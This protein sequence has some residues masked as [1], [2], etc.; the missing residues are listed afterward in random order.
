[1]CNGGGGYNLT[2]GNW[3][4]CTTPRRRHKDGFH[5]STEICRLTASQLGVPFYPDAFIAENRSRIEPDFKLVIN[6]AETN[7]FLYD[8]I[9]STGV[10]IRTCRQLLVDKGHVVFLAVGIMNRKID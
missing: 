6:P 4:I 1:M 5:F 7:V 3:C 2:Q 9:I 8:D 10:T